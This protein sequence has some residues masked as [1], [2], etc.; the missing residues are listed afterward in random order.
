MIADHC[1]LSDQEP[2]GIVL[3]SDNLVDSRA[4]GTKL[5][6]YHAVVTGAVVP[7]GLDA[8]MVRAGSWAVFENSGPFPQ[9]LQCLWRDVFS[10]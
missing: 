10:W 5:G 3:V 9:A 6:Y 8:L 7:E 4:E 1:V 2:E